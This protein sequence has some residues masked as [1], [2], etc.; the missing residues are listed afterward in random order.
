MD[1]IVQKCFFTVES[2]V[3]VGKNSEPELD[4][5]KKYFT[6]GGGNARAVT[7]FA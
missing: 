1:D 4:A 6:L 7:P 5:D 2:G 3:V